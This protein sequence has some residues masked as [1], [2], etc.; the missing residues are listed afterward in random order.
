VTGILL[1]LLA[2]AFQGR[3]IAS[4]STRPYPYATSFAITVIRV[5]LREGGSCELILKDFARARMLTNARQSRPTFLDDPRREID[6]YR[7]ILAPEGIGPRFVT[8]AVDPEADR[9]WLVCEKAPGVE[10]WQ[11][12]ELERWRTVFRWTASFHETFRGRDDE[13]LGRNPG[14]LRHDHNWFT[15]WAERARRALQ[16]STDPRAPRLRH[17]LQGHG[18]LAESLA[19]LPTTFVHGELYPSNVI[20]GASGEVDVWPVDWEMAA[21]GPAMLDVAALVSGWDP[22]PGRLLPEGSRELPGLLD[23]LRRCQ[24]HLA[25]QWLGW[26]SC[27]QAPNAQRHDWLGEATA[28]AEM[29]ER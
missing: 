12:G 16:A 10:L 19:A 4:L 5:G 26:S 27:W 20:V 3:E 23:E 15:S 17:L 14:L 21:V 22:D 18:D 11:V 13:V 2:G 6:T 8:A 7:R 9:Y 24:L 28:L 29:L 25:L 1:E